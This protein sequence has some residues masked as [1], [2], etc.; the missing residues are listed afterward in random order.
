MNTIFDINTKS[1]ETLSKFLENYTMEQ[2][3][4]V[5]DKFSNNIIWNCAHIIVSQ[6]LLTYRLSG[7]PMC[8]S[9]EI[10]NRYRKGTKPE[11][12]VT[13]NG[14]AEIKSLLFVPIEQTKIDYTNKIFVN[15]QEFTTLTGYTIKTIEE[16]LAF[17]NYHEALH[18]GIIMSISKF[19]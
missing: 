3:N 11:Q 7:L 6:Q 1:R 16:A 15:Y 19:V 12:E 2:L 5:P 18:T 8:I 17:N 13:A 10:I 14:V 4:T 9:D